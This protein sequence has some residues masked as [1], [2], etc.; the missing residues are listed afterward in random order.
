MNLKGAEISANCA[1]TSSLM[2]PRRYQ[3]RFARAYGVSRK[4][5]NLDSEQSQAYNVHKRNC[6]EKYNSSIVS[7][8]MIAQNTACR[9]VWTLTTILSRVV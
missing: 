4:L 3:A 2:M 5:D 8:R 1:L 7:I 6:R 9:S